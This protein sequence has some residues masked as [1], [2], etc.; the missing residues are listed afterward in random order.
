MARTHLRLAAAS[1][2][3]A[4]TALLVPAQSASAAT[5]AAVPDYD[6][7]VADTDAAVAPAY[8]YLDERLAAGDFTG[9]PAIVLDIDNTA[10]AS[11]YTSFPR[12]ATPA[13]LDL[14]EY[15]AERDVK[16]FFVTAR[17]DLIDWISKSNLTSVGYTIDGFYSRNFFEVIGSAEKFKTAARAEIEEDGH[18]IIANVGNNWSDLD[19]GYADSTYKLPDYDGELS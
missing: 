16:I 5:D 14:A 10:L 4:A 17:P 19:G 18:D 1:A 13:V 3:L 11:H 2:A 7:W 8:D 12:E 6:T 15:A 9:T